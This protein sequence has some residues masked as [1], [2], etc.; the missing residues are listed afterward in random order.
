[1]A[2]RRPTLHF[3]IVTIVLGVSYKANRP[4]LSEVADVEHNDASIQEINSAEVQEHYS[5]EVQT[6]L[7]ASSRRVLST[8]AHWKKMSCPR[9]LKRCPE[10]SMS[11]MGGAALTEGSE[12]V[13]MQAPV[14]SETGNPPVLDLSHNRRYTAVFEPT[15]ALATPSISWLKHLEI[16]EKLHSSTLFYTETVEGFT[17]SETESFAQNHT[18]QRRPWI[19]FIHFVDDR[20]SCHD[21]PGSCSCSHTKAHAH[22]NA[23][24]EDA[25][26]QSSSQH[27]HLKVNGTIEFS[28]E[29]LFRVSNFTSAESAIGK[30]YGHMHEGK[31]S[32]TSADEQTKHAY[33]F[34]EKFQWKGTNRRCVKENL[35]SNASNGE[36]L[37]G[38]K[39]LYNASLKQHTKKEHTHPTQDMTTF[40]HKLSLVSLCLMLMIFKN[41]DLKEKILV[42]FSHAFPQANQ[43]RNLIQAIMKNISTACELTSPT[44]SHD[45][46]LQASDG[47]A[48]QRGEGKAL[49]IHDEDCRFGHSPVKIGKQDKGR[50]KPDVQKADVEED[51]QTKSKEKASTSGHFYKNRRYFT[52]PT[53]YVTYPAAFLPAMATSPTDK[54]SHLGC[55]LASLYALPASCDVSR[56]RLAQAG[57]YYDNSKTARDASNVHEVVCYSC[58]VT[59]AGWKK[60]DN[61][62]AIHQNLK[63]QCD[64]L[65]SLATATTSP[66]NFSSMSSSGGSS[67]EAGVSNGVL[68]TSESSAWPSMSSG[69]SSMSSGASRQSSLPQ[70]SLSSSD[71]GLASG[72]GPGADAGLEV[73]VYAALQVDNGA[74]R[75]DG[76]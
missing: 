25:E 70:S 75:N 53:V 3:C 2:F 52:I 51:T 73:P 42:P 9:D 59:Y 24:N 23:Y 1:M 48:H 36:Y 62:T 38:Y 76:G 16:T 54:M 58:G 68:S 67:S 30:P 14:S 57:F 29:H 50:E 18:A 60:G 45:L 40:E 64:H 12:V 20:R 35:Q 39:S 65:K 72:F 41:E 6:I 21:L 56:V 63:P 31:T 5:I 32:E 47:L 61:P 44:S 37:Y 28:E 15:P 4:L 11:K 10:S 69:Y 43:I 49:L 26:K 17:L 46:G 33:S 8:R 19:D 7:T 34:E 66:G 55:R 27:T 71:S 13:R 74:R 22:R